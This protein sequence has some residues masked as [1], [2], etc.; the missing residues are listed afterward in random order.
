VSERHI[1]P[2]KIMVKAKRTRRP[3]LKSERNG[4]RRD[5]QAGFSYKQLVEKYQRSPAV[6]ARA[7]RDIK[8]RRGKGPTPP[9]HERASAQ[10]TKA[11]APVTRKRHRRA[12]RPAANPIQEAIRSFAADLNSKGIH[13][14]GLL[15]DFEAQQYRVTQVQTVEG[16]LG[17]QA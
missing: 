2:I 17:E 3:L 1:L 8:S 6:L 5:Y 9:K 10:V 7:L 11:T 4:I 13:L 12:G 15:I 16:N 14:K